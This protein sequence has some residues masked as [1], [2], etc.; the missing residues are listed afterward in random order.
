MLLK[1]FLLTLAIVSNG[2]SI[3]FRINN[4][5]QT[6]PNIPRLTIP[7]IQPPF[8]FKPQN[9]PFQPIAWNANPW[10]SGQSFVSRGPDFSSRTGFVVIS[11]QPQVP[12]IQ[13]SQQALVAPQQV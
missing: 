5:G 10:Q 12:L 3:P 8:F 11:Q 2:Q 6:Y 1:V 4:M 13:Q 9:L 7:Q